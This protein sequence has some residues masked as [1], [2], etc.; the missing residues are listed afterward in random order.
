MSSPVWVPTMKEHA[1]SLELQFALGLFGETDIFLLFSPA[2]LSSAQVNTSSSDKCVALRQGSR[3]KQQK[4]ISFSK[5]Y[6]NIQRFKLDSSYIN[7]IVLQNYRM[8]IILSTHENFQ[9]THLVT[10][11]RRL[12]N[13]KNRP[14]ICHV[15]FCELHFL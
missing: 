6:V 7:N 2:C 1:F 4:Q 14:T 3:G 9:S 13:H 11:L 10:H 5:Q 8:S 12:V 15:Q